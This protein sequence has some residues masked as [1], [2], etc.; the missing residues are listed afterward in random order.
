MAAAAAGQVRS[1]LEQHAR[2]QEADVEQHALGLI[3]AEREE[4]W[5]HCRQ[6]DVEKTGL[7]SRAFLCRSLDEVCGELGWQELLKRAAPHLRNDMVSYGDFLATPRVCW[8]HLGVAQV[9]AIAR[10]TLQAELHLSGLAALFDSLHNGSVQPRVAKQALRVLLPSLRKHQI[11]Q[12]GTALFGDEPTTLSTV[13]HQL[14]LFAD[15]PT[16]DEP[17]MQPALR[18][19]AALIEK[20]H[21]GPPLHCALIRFFQYANSDKNDLLSPTEFVGAFQSLGVYGASGDGEVPLL[22]RGRLHRLFQVIDNNNSGT[23]SFLELLLALDERPSKPELPVFPALE[24]GVPALLLVHKVAVLRICH[25]LDPLG[26]GRISVDNFVE[27]IAALAQVSGQPLT[28]PA[29]TALKAELDG[30]DLSYEEVLR[31]FE[32]SAEGGPWQWGHH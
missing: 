7:I 21:G 31:S 3:C 28:Q 1:I 13:L 2:E 4:L 18:R 25:A 16:L 26:Q 9:V 11:K 29:L 30:E 20:Y 22:H 32:V 15:P 27:L 14:A 5:A 6:H 17:W 23:V 8:F 24:G 12:L 19:L 10:A